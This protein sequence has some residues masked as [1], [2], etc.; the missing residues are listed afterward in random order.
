MDR[1]YDPHEIEPRRQAM[2]RERDVYRTPDTSDKPKFYCLDFFPYP[3]GDGLS[4]GHC[5]NYVP[6]DAISRFKRMNGYNVLHPMGWDAF[7]LPAENYALKMGVRPQVSTQSNIDTY[8]RQMDLIGLSYDWHREIS[9]IDPDYYRWTQWWFLLLFER[10]LAYRAT[11][12]QWWCPSCKTILANEQ[13]E[14]GKCWRC[15]SDVTKVDL[16]QWYFRI[17]EYAQRLL[18]DLATIDWP[19]KIKLMQTN[20][21]GRSDGAEIDF[22]IAPD[23]KGAAGGAEGALDAEGAAGAGAGGAG[24]AAGPGEKLTVFTTR[25]DTLFGAT[26]MVLAPEHPLVDVLTTPQ[27][28]AAVKVYQE[29]ARRE[30]E[31]E[32][33][34]TEKE[35]TGVFI[36]AYAVNP[37]NDERIPIWISDYVLMG[38]GTGAIMAVPA[39]DERDFAFATKFRLPIVEVIAP[40]AGGG[41][42][43]ACPGAS[44]A[45]GG[46]A[47]PGADAAAP[48]S[49]DHAAPRAL[50]DA[51]R[52]A[53]TEA[54]VG[55]GFMVN[56]GR[57]DGMAAPGAAFEA[58]VDWLAERGLARKKV[59]YKLRDWLISRQRYWG[60][61]I[62]IVYCDDCG[63]VPVPVEQLP[64]LL[65]EIDDYQPTGDGRSPLAKAD[66]W[67]NTT[68]PNCGGPGRRETDTMDTFAC[69][70]WY[71]FRFTS[72]QYQDGPFDPAAVA[73]WLPVD[74]YVGGAE[75][76]V[77]HLLYARFFCK[78]ACDADHVGFSE[79]YAALRNQ[80]MIQAE[81]GQKMSKSKGNVVTPDSVVERYGADSL[82]LYELFIAPFEQ[83]VAWSDRGVQGCHRFLS[84]YW[85]LA[86]AMAELGGEGAG[87]TAEA[88]VG[89]VSSATAASAG[90]AAEA[91]GARSLDTAERTDATAA[92]QAAALSDAGRAVLRTV[93][94]T[95]R[96]VTQDMESFRF[97]TAV[98]ALMEAQNEIGAVWHERR[99][100]LTDAEW[101]E[102]MRT[103]T[104][105]LAP[106]APHI[107]DE[108]WDMLGCPGSVL[109]ARWPTW[110]AALAADDTVTVVV[111]VNGKLRDKLAVA[112]GAEKD[113]VLAAARELPNA[114]RF[115]AGKQIVKEIYVRGKL[116]NFV[117]R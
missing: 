43:D 86:L 68:C 46:G 24:G 101:R 88:G 61:P 58:I 34:S 70:S 37:V 12:Q 20:W 26:Y 42:A 76:A 117:V 53:L 21:I 51:R 54:Y 81:D 14:Q 96:K 73:Y 30:S 80:G 112:V 111:Q 27:Q 28:R 67:V 71:H 93:H 69:S 56:S 63:I 13:V 44:A 10:G 79:P 109:D 106:G 94:K 2:W 87:G 40:P 23:A 65:P 95:V 35:K 47:E 113:S 49:T 17:T 110:D 31:I 78:V 84:R 16:E 82:R 85:T 91:A 11:G 103:F 59:N 6:T 45:R 75:H 66:D 15:G 8:K 7:G 57:F 41:T 72:P 29:Q 3:S 74:M 55:D 100:A 97:N 83:A 25:P 50:Q 98:A 99:E 32:R 107:A 36:G 48:L 105:L 116:V 4:V 90:G 62:P 89:G 39:H 64:V 92:S 115:L 19:E 60:A 33:L 108:V 5:R 22:A 104:L 77:M 102:V 52:A 1:R 114:A 38:Y 9:S 18:D